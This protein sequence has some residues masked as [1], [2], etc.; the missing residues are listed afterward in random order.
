MDAEALLT[1]DLRAVALTLGRPHHWQCAQNIAAFEPISVRL[2]TASVPMPKHHFHVEERHG[3]ICDTH[4][5]GGYSADE[6][7]P[8]LPW[9]V[10]LRSALSRSR[11]PLKMWI[12]ISSKA[13]AK[14]HPLCSLIG[15]EWLLTVPAA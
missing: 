5:A 1:G 12:S 6:A 13:T 4:H 15:L 7:Q 8:P 14:W 11:L 9:H 3:L 10:V 2:I